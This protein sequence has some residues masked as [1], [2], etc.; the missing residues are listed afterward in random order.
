MSPRGRSIPEAGYPQGN[1]MN[2]TDDREFV[3]EPSAALP[4]PASSELPS[5][6]GSAL[7]LLRVAPEMPPRE[8][9]LYVR[10]VRALALLGECAPFVDESDYADLIGAVLADAQ[11]NYPLVVRC[12]GERWEVAPLL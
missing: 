4:C 5:P 10:Y 6:E 11:A 9:E 3:P 8:A 1:L 12:H 7:A 2:S